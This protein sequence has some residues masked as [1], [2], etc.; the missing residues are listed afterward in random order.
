LRDFVEK[1]TKVFLYLIIFFLA[2]V[3]VIFIQPPYFKVLFISSV[4]IVI[5]IAYTIEEVR[6]TKYKEKIY[7]EKIRNAGIYEVDVMSGHEFEFFL[8]ELYTS[9]G[10]HAQMTSSSGDFGADLI[11]MNE[12]RRIVL[13]A[14]RY[15][16]NVGVKAVQEVVA[17]QMHY[18]ATE[19]WVVTN[20]YFTKQAKELALSNGVTLIDR[21][22]LIHKMLLVKQQVRN[23]L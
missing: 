19:A 8:K 2:I 9:L 14:K 22:Q 10:Y 17:A 15:S 13:Q 21:D 16:K 5:F 23:I 4:V 12:Y 6:Y 11:L 7:Q 1:I 18:N 20:S 3:G